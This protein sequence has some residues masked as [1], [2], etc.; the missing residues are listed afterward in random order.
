MGDDAGAGDIERKE[1]ETSNQLRIFKGKMAGIGTE[2]TER[3]SR[4]GRV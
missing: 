3:A 2:W 1:R 4:N